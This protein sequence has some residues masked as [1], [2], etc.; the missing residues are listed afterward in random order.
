MREMEAARVPLEPRPYAPEDVRFRLGAYDVLEEI[1]RGGMATVFRAYSTK[2]GRWVAIKRFRPRR[3][4]SEIDLVRFR[5]EV[6]LAARLKH[7]NVVAVFDAGEEDGAP[8]YVMELVEGGNLA[9]RIRASQE[10][11]REELQVLVKVARAL[12]FAH[13]KGIIHRDVKPENVLV[14]ADGEPCLSDFGIAKSLLDAPQLT[15]EGRAL[16]TPFYMP[17]EQANG[18]LAHVGPRS[19]VYA[20]G[21]TLYHVLTTRPPF[22]DEDEFVVLGKILHKE[23]P[24][25]SRRALAACGRVVPRDLETICLKAMEK[26]AARRYETANALAEDL[27]AF[28]AG[29]P[30]RARPATPRERIAR[31][32]RRNRAAWL[33]VVTLIAIAATLIVAFA[34]LSFDGISRTSASLLEKSRTEALRQ[35]ATLERAIRV[36]MLQG[37]A[38]QARALMQLLNA[39][40]EAGEIKVVRTDRQLAYTD[41]STREKV[42][43]WLSTP[44][45]L[46]KIRKESPELVPAVE[47][48]QKVAFPRIDAATTPPQTVAVEKEPWNRA[49]LT[50]K[51][52]HYIEKVGDSSWLVVLWPMENSRECRTCHSE[53]GDGYAHEAVRAVLMVRRSQDDVERTVRENQRSTLNV[54]L[55]TAAAFLAL[56][57]VLIRVLGVRPPAETFGVTPERR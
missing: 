17:P 52:Q 19:D 9:K 45:V 50:G 33:A 44:G 10:L 5:N 39:T 20:L 56:V 29:E 53:P 38:D 14:H 34:A 40:P 49:L 47:T 13:D 11:P 57:F 41:P 8:Y 26:E 51:P 15:R 18:E 1:G 37:R 31:G 3:R 55:A 22:E 6:M 46:E 7:P 43:R 32:L 12:Q 24:L 54:G 23:P 30:I 27:A 35:A 28:L 4:A 2:L 48:L 25:P 21:A 36:N 42:E 16:G